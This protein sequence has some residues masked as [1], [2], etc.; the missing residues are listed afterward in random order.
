MKA[1]NLFIRLLS[2]STLVIG[3]C[4]TVDIGYQDVFKH[5][6]AG[7]NGER[8]QIFGNRMVKT[9]VDV[10]FIRGSPG[11]GDYGIYV[12]NPLEVAVKVRVK[13]IPMDGNALLDPITERIIKPNLVSSWK[14]RRLIKQPRAVEVQY[15]INK[16]DYK[17]LPGPLIQR[18]ESIVLPSQEVPHSE[19]GSPSHE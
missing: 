13:V 19:P 5:I 16:A 17:T 10:D 11:E 6:W 3:V 15:S 9:G 2:L 18:Q 7:Q 12:N 14:V 4:S 1:C 8:Q